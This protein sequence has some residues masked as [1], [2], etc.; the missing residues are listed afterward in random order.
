LKN[1]YSSPFIS[2]AQCTQLATPSERKKT[3]PLIRRQLHELAS[4]CPH[5]TL[6]ENRDDG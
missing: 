4:S 5:K 6:K 1:I 2:A 3:T